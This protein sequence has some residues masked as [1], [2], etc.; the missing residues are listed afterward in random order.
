MDRIPLSDGQIINLYKEESN[1]PVSYRIIKLLS[2]GST[3]LCYKAQQ[4]NTGRTLILK[5]YYPET[6]CFSLKRNSDNG[7]L[8]PANEVARENFAKARQSVYENNKELRKFL[9]DDT[10]NT[11]IPNFTMCFGKNGT[12]DASL[13]FVV[14]QSELETFEEFCQTI[15]DRPDEDSEYKL[16]VVLRS[17]E[18][19]ASCVGELHNA[20]FLHRDIKPQNIAFSKRGDLLPETISLFDIGTFTK[21]EDSS[22]DAYTEGYCAPEIIANGMDPTIRTDIYS[23]GATLF[24]AVCADGRVYDPE[25][26]KDIATLVSSSKLICNSVINSDPYFVRRLCDILEKTMNREPE[27]R[28]RNCDELLSDIK[29]ALSFLLPPE[30]N[31][32][33]YN[34][35]KQWVLTKVQ[36][37]ENRRRHFKYMMLYHLYKDPLYKYSH[38]GNNVNVTVVGF[39]RECHEFL[40]AVLQMGQC[41]RQKVNVK[42]LV[43]SGR[44]ETSDVYLDNRPA[45]DQ[46][47]EIRINGKTINKT[48]F[49]REKNYSFGSI[50]FVDFTGI[51]GVNELFSETYVTDYVYISLG[52]DEDNL[53]YA[54]H[55]RKVNEEVCVALADSKADFTDDPE[56]KRIENAAFVRNLLHDRDLYVNIRKKRES[57]YA[58]NHY[59]HNACVSGIISFKYILNYLGIELDNLEADNAAK[60]T[61]EFIKIRESCKNELIYIEHKRWVVD[62]ICDG[63]A[64]LTDL[65]QCGVLNN[66]KDEENKLHSCIVRSSIYN[67]NNSLGNLFDDNVGMWDE[68]CESLIENMDELDKVSIGLHRVYKSVSSKNKDEVEYRLKKIRQTVISDNKVYRAYTDW[69]TCIRTLMSGGKNRVEL[70]RSLRDRFISAAKSTAVF[71]YEMIQS[72]VEALIKSMY[73]CVEYNKFHN[74]KYEDEKIFDNLPF[75]LNYSLDTVL[76]KELYTGKKK[77]EMFRCFSAAVAANPAE[78]IYC[79]DLSDVKV[80]QVAEVL[81]YIDELKKGFKV[82]SALRLFL[83]Y[84]SDNPQ[85]LDEFKKCLGKD[86]KRIIASVE[87]FEIADGSYRNTCTEVCEQI[88]ASSTDIL[89][90]GDDYTF[91]CENTVFKGSS[92]L[93]YIEHH[94]PYLAVRHIVESS[95]MISYEYDVPMYYENFEPLWDLY[96][97]DSNNKKYGEK[98]DEWNRFCSKLYKSL[99]EHI[100]SVGNLNSNDSNRYSE[101]MTYVLPV[102]CRS[103]ISMLMEFFARYGIIHHYPVINLKSR[104][105]L[106]LTDVKVYKKYKPEFEQLLSN[107]QLLLEPRALE[108]FRKSNNGYF[109][110]YRNLQYRGS[111]LSRL[112]KNILVKLEKQGIV[113]F[114]TD[115]GGF[116]CSSYEACDLLSQEGRLLE[117]LVYYA[118]KNSGL[119]DDVAT[120]IVVDWDKYSNNEMDLIVT[121]GFRSALI[122]CKATKNLDPDYYDTLV[123]KAEKLTVS[124]KPMIITLCDS[125]SGNDRLIEENSNRVITVRSLGTDSQTFAEEVAGKLFNKK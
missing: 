84:Q 115:T 105:E 48:K 122:E 1:E 42:V 51:P 62:K 39:G 83:F 68:G 27:R 79:V 101:G 4:E 113:G 23:I 78:V 112:E 58:N 41:M 82:R 8:Y 43:N 96:S 28:Y 108:C 60:A 103:S 22:A 116:T 73:C 40:D 30:I 86:M 19:L 111:E 107:P 120:S 72:D 55:I 100:F 70:Y 90:E 36:Y 5:E 54:D 64:P 88:K 71:K 63:W 38:D 92:R 109:I 14:E 117:I 98:R 95:K 118:L 85:V 121:K 89:V 2:L 106:L 25:M 125:N 49:E 46:F 114:L 16:L 9:D 29:I 99:K 35:N 110:D 119:F 91:D 31:K 20:G 76:V 102:E 7:Q 15:I 97:E 52:S 66:N 65:S 93:K 87:E 6:T 17:V 24:Y 69:T 74:Y 13:Y 47:F 80:D 53:E 44:Y 81:R 94:L 75:I 77:K 21:M 11:F 18:Q 10:L 32:I 67:S 34:S 59:K 37:D 124:C 26:Y 33:A 57:Y 12:E 123:K 45:L 50:Q 3:V 61:S 104:N 56:F